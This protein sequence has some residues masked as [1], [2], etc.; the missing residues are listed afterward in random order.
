MR[1]ADRLSFSFTPILKKAQL[2]CL[3]FFIVACASSSFFISYPEQFRSKQTEASSGNAGASASALAKKGSGPNTLLDTLESA[4]LFQIGK[5]YQKSKEA[6]QTAF[7]MFNA[8]DN[9]AKLSLS[10]GGALLGAFAVND[11]AIPYKA[12][13]Y[14]RIFSFHYQ[15]LNYLAD[16]DVEGALVEIRRANEEQVFAL[17]QH[18]KELAKAEEEAKKEEL[19]PDIHQYENEMKENFKTAAKVKNSFQNAYTFYYSGI[20]REATGDL[21][22]AY[23][24]YKKALEIYP[25]NNYLQKDVWRL[26]NALNMSADVD[27]FETRIEKENKVNSTNEAYGEL[28]VFYEEGFIPH[29]E[30]IHLP[31]ATFDRI[32]SFAFPAYLTPWQASYGIRISS[33]ERY[34]GQSNEIIDTHTLAAKALQEKAFSRLLRQMIR[35]NTKA[36]LQREAGQQSNNGLGQFF[37]SSYSMIS[38]RADL[39][40]WLSLPKQVQVARFKLPPGSHQIHFSKATFSYISD[41]KIEKNKSTLIRL[42]NPGDQHIYSELFYF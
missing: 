11:N 41:V 31:F 39:R 36:R 40:S 24:D 22:G 8:A 12:E 1:K 25:T 16:N 32:H 14:E 17:E 18:H 4:R 35:V 19:S 21:N 33:D 38:E 10:G 28:I 2:L 5:N 6:F 34:L 13:A 26:A 20:M 7:A 27:Y 3:S 42:T 23:I 30:E 9:K 37:A 29:K 15:S